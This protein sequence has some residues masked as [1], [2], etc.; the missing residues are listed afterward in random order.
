MERN[1]TEKQFRD[2]LNT[3]EIKPSAHAWDRLDAML[4][5]GEG[6]KQDALLAF[7]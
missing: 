3:R 7:C 5:V 1:K 6:K 4:S 2:K